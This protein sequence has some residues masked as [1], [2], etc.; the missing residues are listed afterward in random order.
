MKNA[1]AVPHDGLFK[2]F[3][4]DT[5]TA[6]DFLHLYLPPE[7]LAI[8]DLSTLQLEP[9]SFVDR[10]FRALH[11][12][13]LWSLKTTQGVGYVYALIEH[14][15]TPD[16]H[17]AFRLM[18]Y[19]MSAMKRHLDAGNDTLPLVIPM[20]FYHG[21]LSPYPYSQSWLAD[22]NQPALARQL[23]G[24]N[25]ILVDVTTLPD[26]EIM[27]HRHM[28]LLEFIQKY[29][30]HR[31]MT[32]FLDPL[33]SLFAQGYTDREH[34]TALVTYML[35]ADTIA[36]PQAFIHQL[37]ER[38]EQQKGEI[39]TGAEQF[40]QI[41]LEKGLQQ[42]RQEVAQALLTHGLD[43]EMIIQV[44]GLTDAQLAQLQHQPCN[45]TSL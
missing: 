18:H 19:A 13:V 32:E 45:E 11:S 17:M 31:D 30:R 7:M 25:F 3:L 42:G 35:R 28:A 39:M 33:V 12:D 6:R 38:L 9:G 41:G 26:D 21:R 24:G 29:I 36:D 10:E 16:R 4:T 1:A 15:S 20:L 34:V 22:F 37:A 8:C 27:R 40:E 2:Q 43:R 5:R 23:Y 14:Q 44:T